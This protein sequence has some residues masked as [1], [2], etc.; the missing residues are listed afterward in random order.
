MK[1]RTLKASLCSAYCLF[2]SEYVHAIDNIANALED[3]SD[4]VKNIAKALLAFAVIFAGGRIMFSKSRASDE[5][6][7]L[8]WGGVFIFSG[9]GA[10]LWLSSTLGN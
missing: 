6:G 4:D 9:A 8:F 7:P 5:L 1:K 3:G 10:I 2:V